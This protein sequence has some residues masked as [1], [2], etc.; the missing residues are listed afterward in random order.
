MQFHHPEILYFLFLLLIPILVHLFELRRYQ[1]QQ[2]S[3][4][5][6]LREL[7]Q[8]T[9]KSAKLKKYLLLASRLL[10]LAAAVI[11]FAKPYLPAKDAQHQ[12]NELFVILDNSMSM[13]ANG[14][15]GPLLKRAV[16]E[17]LEVL[18]DDQAFSLLTNDERFLRTDLAS[19]RSELQQIG[20]SP[21][22]FD[23]GGQLSA[24]AQLSPGAGKDILIL[25]DGAGIPAQDLQKASEARF[26][27]FERQP[28]QNASVDSVYVN[29]TLDNFYEIAVVVSKQGEN[30]MEV[31]LAVYN[32]DA[33]VAKTTA[34]VTSDRKTMLFTIPKASFEGRI[35]IS[36]N[37]LAFDNEY[38]FV[39]S[40]PAKMRV[41]AIGTEQKSG[42]LSRIYSDETFEYSHQTLETLDYSDLEQMQTVILNEL[43]EIPQA[44]STTLSALMEKGLR[45]VLIPAASGNLNSYN[46][47]LAQAKIQYRLQNETEKRVAKIEFSHPLFSGVFEKQVQNFDYPKSQVT[48]S[49]S[50]GHP[51]LRYEDQTAFLTSARSGSGLLY[52]FSAPL[53]K[54]FGNFQNS[55]LIVPVFDKMALD[56]ASDLKALVIGRGET[57]EFSEVLGKDEVLKVRG[58]NTEF[59]P[60]QKRTSHR[61]SLVFDQLPSD[62]GI[63]GIYRSGNLLAKT[64]FNF[65]RSESHAPIAA[66][67]LKNVETERNIA[68]AIEKWTENR[69]EMLLWKWF[70]M[71]ALLFMLCEILIQRLLK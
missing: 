19:V 42:F 35:E 45:V 47:F 18:P 17:L 8:Q 33:L 11:A 2:F 51:A 1:R 24:V 7:A 46:A 49:I 32:R 37:A 57:L 31:P 56:H 58:D 14:A 13:Q 25:T 16:Q 63:Y 9:R 23:L 22:P 27:I 71:L 20:Y 15:N 29:Q 62:H 48:L 12:G 30:Q 43:D 68:N 36:D 53:D 3:N 67:A 26:V 44:L 61:V 69:D 59:I 41:L 64:G 55:P 65:D 60:L 39:L 54:T 34:S 28:Q 70:V 10:L 66:S 40:E 4:V 52:A 50:G 6:F 5:Q 21:I 38:F